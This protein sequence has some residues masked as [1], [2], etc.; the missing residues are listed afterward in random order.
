MARIDDE[1]R[2]ATTKP[3]SSL[4][5]L[6]VKRFNGS[7]KFEKTGVTTRHGSNFVWIKRKSLGTTTVVES[8]GKLSEKRS[9]FGVVTDARSR[10]NFQDYSP[11]VPKIILIK[12]SPCSSSNARQVPRE[13]FCGLSKRLI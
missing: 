6:I 4:L 2:E 12:R 10:Q 8:F 3:F 1:R 7:D 11:G 9:V 5:N 13:F